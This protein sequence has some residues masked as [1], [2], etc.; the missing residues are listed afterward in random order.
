MWWLLLIIP[1]AFIALI[2]FIKVRLCLVYEDELN[3]KVK[4]LFFNVPLYPKTEKSYFL[5]LRL[6]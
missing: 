3:V 6:K 2:L 1:L 5:L 4:I